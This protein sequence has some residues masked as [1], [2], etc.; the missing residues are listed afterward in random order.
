M[1]PIKMATSENFIPGSTRRDT[2]EILYI[3]VL[4]TLFLFNMFL[5]VSLRDSLYLYYGLYVFSLAIYVVVYLRGYGYLLGEDLRIF[6]NLYPH[7]FLSLA[8]TTSI[9]FSKK[10]LNLPVLFPT[11]DKICNF[12]IGCCVVMFVSSALGFK[13]LSSSLAQYISMLA[14]V[15]LWISGVIAFKKGHRP[16]KFYIIAWTFITFTVIAVALSLEG[17]LT[18]HDYTFEFVPVGST[19]E[20]LLL[21]FA[22]GDR[23]KTI[24]QNEQKAR[25]ENLLL[26]QNQNQL[27]EK[28][29]KDRTL[30]LSE[31][32]LKLEDSN[33]V[34]NKLFSIIAHDLRSPFNSLIS[35]FSL[36]E[37]DLLTFEE[38]KMLLNEN[39]KNI[40]TIHNTLNNLL[41]WAK[42]QMDEVK[43]QASH[44]DLKL[45]AEDLML[46]YQPLMEKKGLLSELRFDGK[47]V[48][49]ADENQIQ[50]VLRNLIDNAIKFTPQGG[51]IQ[52]ALTET[53]GRLEVCISNT[54]TES[55]VL[56]V[57]DI[58]STHALQTTYGTNMEK[59]VGLGLHLC[60]EYLRNNGSELNA[61]VTGKVVSFY[62]ELGY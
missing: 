1:L 28:Q 12:L 15:I 34:K 9:L 46:V 54:L 41:Y 61:K 52:L 44:F 36:K 14:S 38:L 13:G 40:E 37:M 7:L 47:F 50:L 4:I 29:V 53:G 11:I 3:G 45:I 19:I 59:G 27:L 20:L 25:D 23:Y 51:T 35:I 32:I 55:A 56:D 17:I 16:A 58:M 10:F 18:Y 8:I 2:L 49:Y 22:L 5:Y 62:F 60:K 26:I 30:K 21:S 43:T 42:S 31:T 57:T 48:V 39:Q 24:I 33:A 6:L